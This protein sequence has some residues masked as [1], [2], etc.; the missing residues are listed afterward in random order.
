MFEM[1]SIA[2]VPGVCSK[3]YVEGLESYFRTIADGAVAEHSVI[4]EQAKNAPIDWNT[5]SRVMW[6][7]MKTK[8]RLECGH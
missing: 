8:K 3:K 4:H 2:G 6:S 7:A 5:A 1:V